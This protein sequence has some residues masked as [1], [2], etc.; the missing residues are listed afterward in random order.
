MTVD[1]RFD[2]KFDDFRVE[3]IDR[4]ARIETMHTTATERLDRFSG[5]LRD[6]DTELKKH[7]NE[8]AG[9]KGA[10]GII[11]A[12]AGAAIAAVIHWLAG[13]K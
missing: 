1:P 10:A 11:G 4:L 3:V 8:L 5:I 13:N 9:A 12:G 7:G 6:H 2:E